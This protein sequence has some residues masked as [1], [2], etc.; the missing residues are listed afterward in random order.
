MAF[1][2]LT[3]SFSIVAGALGAAGSAIAGGLAT[4]QHM[5]SNDHLGAPHPDGKAPLAEPHLS[6][7]D[8][9]IAAP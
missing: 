4:G 2:L 5:T 6:W 9:I 3:M 8:E 7:L 1:R